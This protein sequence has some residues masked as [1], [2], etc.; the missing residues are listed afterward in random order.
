M[1]NPRKPFPSFWQLQ[2]MGAACFYV[3]V[4]I[5]S[6]PDLKRPGGFGEQTIGV[7]FLILGTFVMHPICRAFYRRSCSWLPFELKAFAVS[8]VVG[9]ACAFVTE[10]T[11]LGFRDMQWGNLAT[12]SMQFG[13]VLFLWCSLY[14]SIKQWQ[15]ASLERERLLR[16]E[17]EAR[18]ARLSALR[19]Q[20][21]PHF[22]FNSLNA[23][24]TLV[25]EGNA[26][27]ATRMLSQIADLLRTTLEQESLPEVPLSQEVAL[28]RQYLA[29]EQT[30]L[31]DRLRVETAIAP[32]TMDALVPSMLLQPLI[33]NAVRHGVAPRADG[34]TV[35]I[36]S[37]A[38]SGQ[39]RIV[40]R[41]SGAPEANRIDERFG[42]IGLNNTKARLHTLY[43]ED[44][45]FS[46]TCPDGGGC[47]AAVRLPLRTSRPQEA[48]ACAP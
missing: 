1:G 11:V 21:N 38:H 9:T 25:L 4:L 17:S 18:E 39:L 47:E 19:Y 13:V 36:R 10:L 48:L 24:S 45:A 5:G 31:G 6:I 28:A 43:G 14:F 26:A 42:G 20:L 41:N 15:Q 46:L 23:V 40:V 33:E 34:G 8:Q 44:G 37:E 29:I 27:A 22:L 32:E 3:L 16:A 7:A 35:S 30:R 2:I 12:N